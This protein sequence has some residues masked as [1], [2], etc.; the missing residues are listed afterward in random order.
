MG[1][2]VKSMDIKKTP[3][4]TI[5]DKERTV[6]AKRAQQFVTEV[7]DEIQ[8]INWTSR[9]EL[10]TY[11]QIVVVATFLFGMVIYLLDLCIQA[12]LA[13]LHWIVSAIGG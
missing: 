12:A 7:K 4:V 1:A 3:P 6:P 13:S 10:M 9:E 8:K 5:T 2:E 11:T